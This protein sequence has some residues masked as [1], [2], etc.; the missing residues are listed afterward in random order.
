MR[1]RH[2]PL[3][4]LAL[5]AACGGAGAQADTT[6]PATNGSGLDTVPL[7]SLTAIGATTAT[8]VAPVPDPRPQ[9]AVLVGDSLTVQA[10]ADIEAALGPLGISIVGFDAAEGRRVNHRANGQTSGVDAVVELADTAEP[11]LWIVALGTNDVPGIEVAGFRSD[12]DE[13]LAAIPTD[14]PVIWV[15]NWVGRRIDDAKRANTVLREAADDRD[16]MTVVDW[17]QFGDDPGMIRSDGVHLTD[18]GATK[19]AEQIGNE[20]LTRFG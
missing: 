11:D 5:L 14:V 9:T 18:A 2:A 6:D 17:F 1:P 12:V 7:V 3:T 20:L 16:G 19:F 10:Q 4:A 13:L 8:T 15:D